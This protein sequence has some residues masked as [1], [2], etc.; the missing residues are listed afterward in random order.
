MEIKQIRLKDIVLPV[1]VLMAPLAGFT[2]YPFRILCQ[3]LGA[4]L[5]Y[6]EMVSCN[7]LKYK[8]QAT[9]RL[10]LT[11][12]REKIKAAQV[13]GGDPRIMEQMV[14][15]DY[16][17]Q[18]QIVDINMGCPVPNVFKSGEGSALMGD[19]KRAAA[20]IRACKKSGKII[21][22]K[23]RAGLKQNQLIAAEFARMCEDA[24]ADMITIH[25]RSRDMMYD[26]LPYY[27]QIKQAKSAVAIPVIANGGIF[28]SADAEKMME[29]TG[30]AGIM[31]ARYGLENPFIF[32]ELTGRKTV[33][34]HKR[35]L[36][37]QIQLAAAGY[38]ET[39]A[40]AYIKK[41]ASYMMKRKKG[42]KQLKLKLHQTGN[43]V[44]LTQIIEMIFADERRTDE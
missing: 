35:I 23:C 1:N 12:D 8:D 6:N 22:V 38:G 43:L 36:T 21:T 30:A 33:P 29:Q 26:G 10:L 16:F 4:G 40:L 3:D 31:I 9:A 32:S 20:L 25:G 42:T 44:E 37:E 19:L 18:Y 14:Q 41:I 39:F 2:C 27:D 11:T 5:C 24:G 17:H 7:A 28:S 13:L 15:S 34:S